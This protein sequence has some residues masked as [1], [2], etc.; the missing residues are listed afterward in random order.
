MSEVTLCHYDVVYSNPGI[1]AY[2]KR[3]YSR[4]YVTVIK[5]AIIDRIKL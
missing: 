3:V 5:E 4:V 1:I 2:N